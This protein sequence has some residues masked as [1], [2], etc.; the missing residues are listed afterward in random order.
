[1]YSLTLQPAG[2][3]THSIIGTFD[4]NKPRQQ[5]ILLA[6]CERLSM[7][8]VGNDQTKWQTI[9]TTNTFGI[10]RK[11]AAIRIPGT[12]SDIL[13]VTS[14]SGRIALLEYDPDKNRFDHVHLETYG[15]S[16]IRR[17]IPGMYL[18]VDPRGRCCM[19]ASAEKNKIVYILNRNQEQKVTISSPQ[20][21]TQQHTLTFALCAVDAN[22]Q[23]PLF[24][25]LEVVTTD[26]DHDPTDDAYDSRQ[27]T[28]VYYRVDLGLN[29]V[30]RE[31]SA[32]VDYSS[33]A[34][35]QVPGGND[36]PSGVIVCA[37]GTITYLNYDHQPLTIKIPRRRGILENPDRDRR[38]V[39]GLS[40]RIK[41]NFFH[42]LQTD[43]GDVFKLTWV[44]ETDANGHNTGTVAAL[45]LQYF[46]TLPV[47][48]TMSI[49][50]FD[51]AMFVASDSGNLS[52]YK[53][54]DLGDDEPIIANSDPDVENPS[55][56][57][58]HD[59]THM[60]I[61]SD[62]PSLNPQK[63]ALVD[64][65]HSRDEHK[66]YSINGTGP[67]STLRT[68]TH[69]LPV[70]QHMAAQM[71]EPVQNMWSVSLGRAPNKIKY[72]ILSTLSRA[73]R[74]DT[75]FLAVKGSSLDM[76]YDTGMRDDI[77][78][79]HI[80]EMGESG[81]IQVWPKGFRYFVAKHQKPADWNCPMHKT[82]LKACSNKQQLVLALDTGEIL[83]YEVAPDMLSMQ[84]YSQGPRN[85]A[86]DST[87]RALA[88]GSVPEGRVRA[89]HL[90]VALDDQIFIF[91]LD[92]N[93]SM[94]EQT[95]ITAISSPARSMRIQVMQDS[96][97][98]S[99]FLHVGLESGVYLRVVL[100][101]LSG[102]LSDARKWFLGPEPVTLAPLRIRDQAVMMACG[103]KTFL[104]Y[105][106][107]EASTCRV[108]PV[109][110]ERIKD[111]AMVSM[112]KLENGILGAT[113]TGVW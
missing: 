98:Y 78:T 108:T 59:L 104:C 23:N 44:L 63:A 52:T 105:F 6:R 36:G 90:A 19:L 86:M 45:E 75:V 106:H 85:L 102:E 100:D 37:M 109:D 65:I 11:M 43:D 49:L 27:K 103:H 34:L 101:D 87:V 29:H 70:V 3:V 80:A 16:G 48:S 28:L 62:I 41:N 17:T 47:A 18:A 97:G 58:P 33:N 46:D 9:L 56:F 2:M 31:W 13:I 50:K 39:S 94:L 66:I 77:T 110:F 8:L 24:A 54:L 15:K 89:P 38:I 73:K 32:A 81:I 82:I 30:V 111:A 113:L 7:H 4:R 93:G 72:V 14:D 53:F 79:L 96:T 60:H 61:F 20:E 57:L 35:Y 22:F 55:T 99:T 40:H 12:P 92:P 67:R 26:I 76:A 64:D 42:L 107:T 21:I 10:I 5:Q 74:H 51:Q 71:P 83:Y 1:M 88:I 25:A 112:S 84:E 69:G 91:S 68:I 95:T